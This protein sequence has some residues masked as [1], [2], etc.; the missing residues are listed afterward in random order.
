MS[1]NTSLHFRIDSEKPGFSNN[2][3]NAT[4][5][6]PYNSSAVQ[7][8]L[9]ITDNIGL[10]A[11]RLSHNDTSNGA[12]ANESVNLTSGISAGAII[13]YTI[14]NFP[15]AGG[16]LGWRVWAND[17]AGNAN[18]SGIYTLVVQS[19]TVS[20]TT[21]PSIAFV[22]PT[23]AN[24]TAVSQT[25]AV[26]NVTID[27]ATLSEVKYIWNGT[28]YTLYN[29][30]LLLMMN[31]ENRSALGENST[32]VVDVS[33]F[34]NNGTCSGTNCPIW[35]Y[36]NK[37]GGAYKYD[38]SDDY[39]DLGTGNII[40][41]G[42]N[43]NSISLWMYYDDTSITGTV[44]S[45]FF[46]KQD[47]QYA[48]Y[49]F[50]SGGTDHI[51]LAFRGYGVTHTVPSTVL[52]NWV[53][54]VA[55]YL[56]GDKA[57]SSNYRLYFNGVLLSNSA[58]TTGGAATYNNIGSQQGS[59]SFNGYIDEFRIWNRSLSASEVNQL[60]MSNLQKFN[61]THW[62]LYVNQ[63]KNATTGLENGTYTYRAFA[64]DTS[65]NWNNT[66]QRTLTIDATAPSF[67]NNQTNAS[68]ATQNSNVTFN[69]T[70][71]DNIGLSYFI[72]S[73]NGTGVWDNA[74][75]GTLSGA[76]QNVTVNK[77]PT[78][79]T[80]NIVAYRWYANDSA[81]NLNSSIL[82][83]FQIV[84]GNTAPAVTTPTFNNTVP[85]TNDD[86]RTNTT[87]SD[88]N[89][90]AGT[91]TFAW[92][93]NNTVIYTENYTAVASGTILF[94]NFSSRFFAYSDRINVTVNATD[95]T[96]G[97]GTANSTNI[98]VLNTVPNVT[99]PTL[100]NTSPYANEPLSTNTTYTDLDGMPGT[101]NFTWYV[102]NIPVF[103]QTEAS[104][105][106]NTVVYSNLSSGY[107]TNG[108]TVNLSVVSFDGIS[109]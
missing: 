74:T 107:F 25:Y 103:N 76:A 100:N 64:F 96:D 82:Y 56:G 99:T 12:W 39:I 1:A 16:T 31:F 46:L 21:P 65:N 88:D 66:E 70:I 57:T 44:E 95:G 87:Y 9:T 11:Y 8:N 71:T 33:R 102:N 83:S 55:V 52:Q 4:S 49:M 94:S 29:D 27:E 72:F 93:I 54:I 43:P 42:T 20:D 51:D 75:N 32:Y 15:A 85:K 36:S 101:V 59:S 6:A 26:I 109:A 105:A 68:S 10:S 73:W 78:V 62:E 90:D 63:S 41:T 22:S 58:R 69:I 86:L 60:Y 67:S 7:I 50:D 47:T 84:S 17:T 24:G 19:S 18:E 2:Q 92:K 5:N 108:N 40:P 30:S 80:N 28:N 3:T 81:G 89:G 37:Y 13:N 61:S 34:G 38:G 48:L 23:P 77:T 14:R 106:N 35:N 98:T 91:L 53:H 45:I 104:I 97:S 79:P